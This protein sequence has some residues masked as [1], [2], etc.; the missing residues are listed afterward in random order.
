[1]PLS[2]ESLTHGA[3]TCNLFAPQSVLPED[4]VC[5]E[6]SFKQQFS[7]RNIRRSEISKTKVLTSIHNSAKTLHF[8]PA[9][10]LLEQVD[11]IALHIRKKKAKILS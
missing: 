7:R 8:L 5:A 10:P 6:Y 9:P 2:A 11:T 3:D 1:M 4:I